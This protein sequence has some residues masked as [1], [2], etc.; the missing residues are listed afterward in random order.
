MD[1]TALEQFIKQILPISPDFYPQFPSFVMAFTVI[2]VAYIFLSYC[3]YLIARKAEVKNAWRAYVPV[4]NKF[5]FCDI[6]SV[7]YIWILPGLFASLSLSVAKILGP[8]AMKIAYEIMIIWEIIHI[9]DLAVHVY[10]WSRISERFGKPAWAGLL[11]LL[12][13]MNSVLIVY[14]AFLKT[15]ASKMVEGAFSETAVHAW[16]HPEILE[17]ESFL[18][19]YSKNDFEKKIRWQSKRVGN[20]AYDPHGKPLLDPDL[21]PVFV[22]KEELQ[23]AG[24]KAD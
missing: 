20:T 19:N 13:F 11:A 24:L 2:A 16:K 9:I 18:N 23:K 4:L 15:P 8:E 21:H 22:S 12:D 5:L 1:K 14:F 7:S 3:L 17:G 10:I 6:A